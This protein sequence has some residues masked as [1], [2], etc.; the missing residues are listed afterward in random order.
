MLTSEYGTLLGQQ[1]GNYRVIELLTERTVSNLY[2]AQDVNLNRPVF[3]EILHPFIKRNSELA[4]RFRQRMESTGQLEHESVAAVHEVGISRANVI[5]AAIEYV[6][7][8]PLAQ[9]LAEAGA[10]TEI[11]ALRLVRQI[12][13]ALTVA[14]SAGIVHHD[15]RP[16]NIIITPDNNPILVDLGV[17][18]VAN[19]P[20]SLSAAVESGTLDYT[21]PEHLHGDKLTAQ[22]NIYSLG[23]I[24]YELLTGQPPL[25]TTSRWNIV[26]KTGQTRVKALKEAKKGLHPETYHL[27]KTCLRWRKKDRYQS[28]EQ[29]L[30]AVD[31]AI[32]T[33]QSGASH[34]VTALPFMS[35]RVRWALAG[36]VFLLAFLLL[37]WTRSGLSYLQLT[38]GK[39]GILVLDQSTT[40]VAGVLVN[41]TATAMSSPTVT[42]TSL[43]EIPI[44][45]IAPASN[46]AISSGQEITFDWTYEDS[47][48][49]DQ[50]F[51]VYLLSGG[52]EAVQL[53]PVTEPAAGSH[54]S[55]VVD[56]D[57]LDIATGAYEWQI[58]LEEVTTGV[59]VAA[60]SQRTIIFLAPTP[61]SS[62]S[63]TATMTLSPTPPATL[64][65]MPCNVSPR[66]GWV[67][68]SVQS[69]DALF[70][71]AIE[72]GTSV[73]EILLVNCLE[74]DVVRVGRVLWLPPLP[75]T[76]TPTPTATPLPSP[77]AAEG[78]PSPTPPE[79]QPPA[80]TEEPPTAEPATLTPEPLP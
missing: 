15:L 45:L 60:S 17:P 39:S 38:T 34:T 48:E 33:L 18:I 28:M 50:Q 22:G 3:L 4:V 72:R 24:L 16:E 37:L 44:E 32:A 79:T 78:T 41:S 76:D 19:A 13:D 5:F 55:L 47:L 46:S 56:S 40:A 11:E 69:G 68:Y 75:A 36:V 7:G 30:E 62:P 63:P 49:R 20:T 9:K 52:S 65:P 74:N 54:Y 57:E 6:P 25:Q 21:P 1:I 61:T 64:T 53:G 51:V 42:P 23:I 14:H 35:R 73:E 67:R 80:P 26:R 8:I 59:Q 71:L 43:S 29:M 66:P 27:V 12:A 58:I 70:P 2:L 77:T 31:M 10:F